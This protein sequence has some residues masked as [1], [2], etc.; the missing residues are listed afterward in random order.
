MNIFN[1]QQSNLLYKISSSTIDRDNKISELS[2]ILKKSPSFQENFI[3]TVVDG[4][5][6]N[7]L[8]GV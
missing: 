7:Y 1:K 6:N 5:K 3:V 2:E 8:S 4:V